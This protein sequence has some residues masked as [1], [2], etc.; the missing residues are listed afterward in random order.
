[1]IGIGPQIVRI[2]GTDKNGTFIGGELVL[3]FMFWPM[4]HVGLWLEPAY[5]LVFRNEVS[6]S[7]GTTGGVIF[8]W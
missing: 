6:H 7:I 5:A 3:D 4:R 8:G 1:M 2:S